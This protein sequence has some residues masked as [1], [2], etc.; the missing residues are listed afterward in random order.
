MMRIKKFSNSR[1]IEN[2]LKLNSKRKV[3]VKSNIRNAHLFVKCVIFVF[4]FIG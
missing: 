2:I 3:E 4:I 1:D